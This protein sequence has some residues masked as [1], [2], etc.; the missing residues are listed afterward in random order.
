MESKYLDFIEE[1]IPNRKTP[2]VH[3]MN[4]S[5]T[6]LGMIYFYPSWRKFIFRPEADIIFDTSCL[7]DI[8]NKLNELQENWK[9]GLKKNG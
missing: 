3:V 9:E 1:T 4:K 8:V 7:L 2:I 6:Y 5:T